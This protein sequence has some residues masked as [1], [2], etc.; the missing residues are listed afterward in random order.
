[1]ILILRLVLGLTK[2]F[3][4]IN[5]DY[6]FL[7]PVVFSSFFL[8]TKNINTCRFLDTF[9]KSRIENFT[10]RRKNKGPWVFLA[11]KIEYGIRAN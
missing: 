6:I 8:L 4:S 11:K 2:Y 9:M 5:D 3:Y 1:M 7:G 10:Q